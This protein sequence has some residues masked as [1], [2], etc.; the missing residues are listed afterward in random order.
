MNSNK[1]PSA[2]FDEDH[3]K[4]YD[5]QWVKLAA[6]K[7]AL[8]LFTRVILSD[9]PDDAHILCVGVGTGDELFDLAEHNPNWK[10]TAID[11]SAPMLERCMHRAQEIGI[12]KRCNF[13]VGY[14]DTLEHSGKFDAATC[15]LVAHFL[16]DLVQR[17]ALITQIGSWLR[18]NGIL[19]NAELSGDT[20]SP[21]FTN[22]ASVWL[23]MLNYA[24][25]PTKNIEKMLASWENEV[26]ILP[27]HEIESLISKSGFDEPTLFFQS[28]LV[29]AWYSR[30]GE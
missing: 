26:A 30:L 18:P 7:D 29:H 28:L 15:F 13:H 21:K 24:E 2:L 23:Q 1:K 25:L 14:L 5:G 6:M 16:T 20:K 19:I 22:L 11:P 27:P 10:F 17:Q 4:R 9:L 3:A 8:H 12:D